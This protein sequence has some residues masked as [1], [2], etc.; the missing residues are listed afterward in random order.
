MKPSEC[1]KVMEQAA[2]AMENLGCELRIA[3]LYM[4]AT[5]PWPCNTWW[6]RKLRPLQAE[7]AMAFGIIGL[8]ELGIYLPRRNDDTTSNTTT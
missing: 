1:G 3:S 2:K 5:A 8:E 4:P 7:L 6:K